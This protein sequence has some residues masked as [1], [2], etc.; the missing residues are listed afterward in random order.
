[1][2]CDSL[3]ATDK[4]STPFVEMDSNTSSI[5]SYFRIRHPGS[6]LDANQGLAFTP[7]ATQGRRAT[8]D[9]LSTVDA[10]VHRNLI[11]VKRCRRMHSSPT[12][13]TQNP[14]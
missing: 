3:C 7:G 14:S 1:M 9:D 8:F 2:V 5:K 12:P 4:F 11:T 6:P 13:W 10:D